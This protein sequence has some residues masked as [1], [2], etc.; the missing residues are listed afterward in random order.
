MIF[1]Q[2]L[3][4]QHL[5]RSWS[6]LRAR[7]S[8]QVKFIS[9]WILHRFCIQGGYQKSLRSLKSHNRRNFGNDS[10]GDSHRRSRCQLCIRRCHRQVQES[11]AHATCK[12]NIIQLVGRRIRFFLHQEGLI[13]H[14]TKNPRIF[15][16]N[17]K[18]PPGRTQHCQL[19]ESRKL[20]IEILRRFWRFGL[21]APVIDS[22]LT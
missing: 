16:S 21:L 11:S 14:E 4:L 2:I 13:F 18:I 22:L 20:Q 17:I 5:N 6:H 12:N 8:V 9:W 7:I 10:R 3:L 19:V 15:F 1:Q